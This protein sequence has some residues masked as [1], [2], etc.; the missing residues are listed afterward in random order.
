MKKLVVL[1]LLAFLILL[2]LARADITTDKETYKPGETVGIRLSYENDITE[3]AL[4]IINPIGTQEAAQISMVNNKVWDYNYTLETGA[5]NGT[6]VINMV[7]SEG[8]N[9]SENSTKL[10]FSKNFDVITPSDFSANPDVIN[11]IVSETTENTIE[12][13]NSGSSEVN[14]SEIIVLEDLVGVVSIVQRPYTIPSNSKSIVKIRIDPSNLAQGSYKGTIS[15]LSNKG[16][17]PIQVNLQ[18]IPSATTGLKMNIE[19]YSFIIWT[20]AI[21]IVV[22]IVA[23]T[24]LRYRKIRKKKSQ[25]KKKIDQEKKKED[26]YYKSQEEYRTEYY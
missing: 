6:Y 12:L 8:G 17:I 1:S 4:Y 2:Q 20:F 25:E 9:L 18:V 22:V 5:I 16:V 26:A 19:D 23:I 15:I 11:E 21:F 14:I 3:V 7:A 13:E 24:I 10:Y